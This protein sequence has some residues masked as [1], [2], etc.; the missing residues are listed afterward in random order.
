MG[1][2]GGRGCAW[3]GRVGWVRWVVGEDGQ[4]EAGY[5]FH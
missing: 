5:I 3:W 1:E 2:V 4:P